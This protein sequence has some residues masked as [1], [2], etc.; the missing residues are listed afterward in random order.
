MSAVIET[1]GLTKT[2]GKSRGIWEVNLT[3]NE[4]EVL[5]FLWSKGAGKMTTNRM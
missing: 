3:V 2:Y 1:E 4:G 5:C